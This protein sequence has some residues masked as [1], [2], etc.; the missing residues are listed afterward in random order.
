MKN[1]FI[2]FLYSFLFV[3]IPLFNAEKKITQEIT[4][5][6]FHKSVKEEFLKGVI[7]KTRIKGMLLGDDIWIFLEEFLQKVVT[8][9]ITE[10]ALVEC[11]K[12]FLDSFN[13][14]GQGSCWHN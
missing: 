8:E 5:E 11:F 13:T 6:S 12:N 7:E 9:K 2:I 10:E 1:N 3:V 14:G 4:K